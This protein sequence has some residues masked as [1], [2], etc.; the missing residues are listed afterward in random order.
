MPDYSMVLIFHPESGEYYWLKEAGTR[1]SLQ[2]AISLSERDLEKNW[3]VYLAFYRKKSADT[4]LF[5]DSAYL[6]RF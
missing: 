5:S 1:A 2:A 6:G 3:C 4:Y